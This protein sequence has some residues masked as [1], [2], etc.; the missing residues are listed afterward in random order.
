[1]TKPEA[2]RLVY[3]CG[4]VFVGLGIAEALCF[5]FS[6]PPVLPSADISPAIVEGA[7][8]LYLAVTESRKRVRLG[9]LLLSA[10][11]VAYWALA[12]HRLLTGVFLFAALQAGAGAMLMWGSVED[13]PKQG[14]RLGILVAAGA[15][16]LRLG[17]N[18]LFVDVLR[19]HNQAG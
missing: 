11:G 9:W 17:L 19:R 3:I 10:L 2:Y 6:L 14:M 1:M 5:T 16:A 18:W 13:V 15:I 12:D 4:A 8:P 7:L